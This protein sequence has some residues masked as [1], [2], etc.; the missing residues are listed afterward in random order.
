MLRK[1]S[2]IACVI[3]NMIEWYDFGLFGYFAPAINTWMIHVTNNPMMPAL[4]IIAGG[5]ITL[6]VAFFS[7]RREF[8]GQ[9]PLHM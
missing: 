4:Y 9:L 7:V 2:I 5:L 6:F 3:G 8:G 1:K